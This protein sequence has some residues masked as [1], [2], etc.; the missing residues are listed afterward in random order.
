MWEVPK[1][2]R[3]S[4]VFQE[5]QWC[6]DS[7]LAGAAC[8]II[9]PFVFSLHKVSYTGNSSWNTPFLE[10]LLH[11]QPTECLNTNSVKIDIPFKGT[12]LSNKHNFL[13]IGVLFK[14]SSI[15]ILK[16]FRQ[17]N[18]FNILP[19][20]LT[21]R[22]MTW[23]LRADYPSLPEGALLFVFMLQVYKNHRYAQV[24]WHN[25]YPTIRSR[26]GSF[27]LNKMSP[28]RKEG[29]DSGWPCW[30]RVLI[31]LQFNTKTAH[32]HGILHKR[33]LLGILN[34]AGND[35]VINEATSL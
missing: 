9:R 23:R 6:W 22:P 29:A 26:S 31:P 28:A 14:M 10:R 11:L 4:E 20:F 8:N 1:Y 7:S 34:N 2:C 17:K 19:F 24:T 30:V 5:W 15:S 21:Y 35:F 27:P 13:E 3:K 16:M 12:P 33:N 32:Y 25:P 18:W